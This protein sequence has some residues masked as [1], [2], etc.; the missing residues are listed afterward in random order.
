MILILLGPPGTGKGTQGK[1][2]SERLQ[3]PNISTGEILRSAIQNQTELGNKAKSFIDEGELVPDDVMIGLIEQRLQEKDC[4]PGFILDG[5][6]R[7]VSQAKALETIFE[8]AGLTLNHVISFELS[9][10]KIIER[11]T[12]RRICRVCGKDYNLITNPP[13]TDNRCRN[14]DGEIVQR[15]DDTEATVRNRLGV[16]EQKT[17]P[18]KE[19]FNR[20]GQLKTVNAAGSVEEI[21]HRIAEILALN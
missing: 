16:Y 20:K 12:S 18:L 7:T 4:Q 19:Y 10:A 14:C 13:P 15:S 5:F 6:P 1:L 11:L 21:Q 17:K 3:I 2:L 8:R 9:A